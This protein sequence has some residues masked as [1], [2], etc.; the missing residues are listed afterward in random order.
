[1]ILPRFCLLLTITFCPFLLNN[2]S[3]AE[4]EE[5]VPQY[6]FEGITIP[7]ASA[8]E[9]IRKEFSLEKAAGYLDQ[10]ATAWTNSHGCVSCHT[11]GSYMVLRPSLSELLGKPKTEM[12]DFF[13]SE[14]ADY[15]QMSRKELRIGANAATVVYLA[16][17]LAE[18]DKHVTGELS[19]ETDEALRFMFEIEEE[20]GT[21]TSADCWPPLESSPYQIAS[22]ATIATAT[23]PGWLE[24]V[25]DDSELQT[26]ITK[27]KSYMS[28]TEPP[29]DYGRV[30]L[31]WSSA[32]YP[33]LLEEAKQKELIE[34][35]LS[36]QNDDGGWSVRS[37][38]QP[39]KWGKGNRA[40]RLNAET[41][42]QRSASDGHQ[43]GL[44]LLVLQ[45][46]GVPAS[47]P[48][49]QK[50][51]NWLLTNQRESGRWWTRS[52]NTD[53]WHYVTFSGSLYPLTALIKYGAV[54]QP[55]VS[56]KTD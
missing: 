6:E 10:G 52:L 45:E 47:D 21:W 27:L 51:L 14:L 56:L 34:L 25:K 9:P 24:S 20:N 8:D 41:D 2:A 50:G 35:L 39:E 54:D 16:A 31:L 11:T 5:K 3:A 38:S 23:A 55:K 43:S 49:V 44:A 22:V 40:E 28:G 7:P 37:F 12:R 1:M 13:V 46:A 19:P 26:R 53:E 48:R 42:E 4:E 29:H 18:W 30:L 33:G 32:R 15:K 36:H 17:G